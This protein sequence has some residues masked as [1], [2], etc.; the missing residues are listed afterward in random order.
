MFKIS[1]WTTILLLFIGLTL[2]D[3]PGMVSVVK[4]PVVNKIRDKY[5]T[6]LFTQ[7]GHQ[8]IPD[9]SSGDVT[10][11]DITLDLT[12]GDANNLKVSF[13]ETNNALYIEVDAT[14]VRVHLNWKYDASLLQV[15]G[16]A[17]V[18]GPVSSLTLNLG[19]TTKP[20]ASYF[21]PQVNVNS[22][23]AQLN[24]D[25]F[26]LQFHCDGCPG[27]V[28]QLVES[29]IKD[30]L[31]DT[32]SQA[33]NQQVPSQ[34]NT[35]GNQILDQSFPRSV[36]MY[37]NLDV[38]TAMT[39]PLTIKSDHIE[40]PLDSTVFLKEDGYNRQGDA[41]VI[42]S[43][44]PN[45]PGEIQLFLSSYLLDTLSASLNKGVQTFTTAVKGI[46][47]NLSID[48]AK[49]ATSLKFEEGSFDISISPTILVP[50]YSVGLQISA[51]A[52]IDPQIIPGDAKDMFYVSPKIK[53]FKMSNLQ[54]IVGGS[55]YSLSFVKSFLNTLFQYVINSG[56]V[57][58]IGAPKLAVL[59]LVVSSSEL[60]FHATY[61]E[62]GA[63]FDFGRS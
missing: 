4:L 9:M 37:N 43:Y 11:K 1:T 59:P 60:D 21:I 63:I 15:S 18:D 5:F 14:Q 2:A 35:V 62:F 8:T 39:G 56:L 36:S 50:S 40:V 55:T 33:I 13:D 53:G 34:L 12:N 26:N 29:L 52:Q 7:F 20:E 46:Q 45:D 61:S 28:E 49:G 25:A 47:I 17:T 10:I 24:K 19:F 27:F 38:A 23:N 16:D 6:T 41:P 22:F 31:L 44:N 54:L 30:T 57:P 42:P 51:S 48:P 3:N 58:K 32:V